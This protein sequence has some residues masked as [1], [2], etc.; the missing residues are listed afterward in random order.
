METKA[1]PRVIISSW[2]ALWGSIV[3]MDNLRKRH[4]I[5]INVCPL[6][7]AAEKILD[8]VLVS[9]SM[10]LKIWHTIL[11]WFGCC[12]VMLQDLGELFDA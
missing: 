10:A 7:L 8:H 9:C 6:C 12:W 4:M 5:N 11:R 1:P 3:T 2:L